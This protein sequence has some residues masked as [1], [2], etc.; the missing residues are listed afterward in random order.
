MLAQ[1]PHKLRRPL[2]IVK[3]VFLLFVGGA[4]LGA[5]LGT[6]VSLAFPQNF[7]SIVA[8]S[9]VISG[10]CLVLFGA[11]NADSMIKGLQPNPERERLRVQTR[12]A[13]LRKPSRE[14]KGREGL[15]ALACAAGATALVFIPG[16]TIP[17]FLTAYFL[18]MVPG[19]VVASVGGKWERVIGNALTSTL[20]LILA[21]IYSLIHPAL[22]LERFLLF[23]AGW[24]LLDALFAYLGVRKDVRL[25]KSPEFFEIT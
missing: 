25:M 24:A 13:R 11:T 1:T 12:L 10:L 19:K 6:L 21:S 5:I 3:M 22:G 4:L 15:G 7:I 2:A 17:H 8:S 14:G 23:V 18:L 20:V 9:A 16:A